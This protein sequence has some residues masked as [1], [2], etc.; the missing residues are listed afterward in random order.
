MKRFLTRTAL[1]LL[2]LIAFLIV[3]E[4]TYRRVDNDYKYKNDWL[5]NNSPSIQ[6][7]NL[8]SSHAYYGIDPEQFD[9]HAFNAA[10][11]SQDFHYDAFIFD[12]FFDE[13]DSLEYLVLP[14]SYRSPWYK[15]ESND[16]HWRITQYYIYY[17]CPFHNE[18]KYKVKINNGLQLYR[19]IKNL[20]FDINDRACSDL[21]QGQQ[22]QYSNRVGNL[23]VVGQ[24]RV[25]CHTFKLDDDIYSWNYSL[26]TEI[27]EKC[28][29][30][31]VKVI[32]LTTPVFISYRTNANP[33]QVEKM[34]VFCKTLTEAYD[35]VTYLNLW[36]DSRFDE[37][38]FYDSDHLSCDRGAVK[39]SKILNE[40]IMSM[41]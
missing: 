11:V 29:L 21:G 17:D 7:L 3:C 41:R 1:I 22:F 5:L 38:D 19:A 13:M 10:H 8:G 15:I 24:K 40:Y 20:F 23:D 4:F 34:F 26:V 27:I 16:E 36:E 14:V 37:E 39:L 6:V 12:K 30:R 32:L 2:P 25:M 9:L 18:L 28:H 33:E 31:G 35:N